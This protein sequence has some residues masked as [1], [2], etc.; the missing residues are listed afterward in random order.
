MK[1]VRTSVFSC[2]CLIITIFLVSC[3]LP[4]ELKKRAQKQAG[5]IEEAQKEVTRQKAQYTHLKES[6]TFG[7]FNI[8]AEREH[9]ES[10]FQVALDDL[11]R[12]MDEIVNPRL[13][14]R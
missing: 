8:Y 14:R 1:P 12:A 3:G 11:Q 13:R 10:N 9:W 2:F 5:L 6:E 7:F 4:S